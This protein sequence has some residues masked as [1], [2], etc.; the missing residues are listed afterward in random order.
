MRTSVHNIDGEVSLYLGGSASISW[1]CASAKLTSTTF[2]SA[3]CPGMRAKWTMDVDISRCDEV[4]ILLEN[5][6][7]LFR[8]CV[9]N[10]ECSSGGCPDYDPDI[11][12]TSSTD[13]LCGNNTHENDDCLG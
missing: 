6:G 3:R 4:N 13:M 2:A 11:Q 10:V 12:R 9:E 5:D 7:R 1:D 8:I